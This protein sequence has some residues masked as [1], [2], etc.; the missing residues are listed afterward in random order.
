[1]PAWSKHFP[2]RTK[3]KGS[4]NMINR[5]GLKQNKISIIFILGL[6]YFAHIFCSDQLERE[7]M[8]IIDDNVKEKILV[9]LVNKFGI[10]SAERAKI[11]INQV[12]NFWRESDGSANIF[13]EFCLNHFISNP[14]ELDTLF[15]TFQKNME[16]LFGNLHRISRQFEWK[17]QVESGIISPADYLFAKYNPFA[18]LSKDFFS[19]KLAFTALLNF[20]IHSLAEKNKQGLRWDRKKWAETRLVEEFIKRIPAEVAQQHSEAYMAADDYINHYNIYMHNLIDNQ[21]KIH[22]PAGLKLISHWGLRDELKALYQVADGFIRQKMI[23]EVM[24]R[25]IR[26]ETPKNIVNSEEYYWNP[27]ENKVFKSIGGEPLKIEFESNLRYEHILNIFYAEQLLDPFYPDAPSLIDRQFNLN[28]EMLEREVETELKSILT[29]PV[30]KEISQLIQK[31]LGRPLEPFDIWYN[32]FKT[33]SIFPESDLDK[34]VRKRYPEVEAF[35]KDLPAI[36]SRLGFSPDKVKFLQQHIQ[37]DPSRG[38]GHAL[39]AR[40]NG[41]KAHL[42]TRIPSDGMNYKGY[43]IAIHELGHNVEQIF[44]LNGMDYYSLNG[45]PNTAFTE[46][47]AFVFQSRNLDILGVS[48]PTEETD[49][50]A[51]LGDLWATFEISGVALTDMAIWHWLYDNPQATSED[52]KQAT[53]NISKQIWNEYF[54][55]VIGHKNQELLAIYSHIVDGG[56]YT[57][58]YPLGHI[59]SFQIEQ[60]LKKY[61]LP[62]EMERMCRIGRLT[63]QVWMQRA[64]GEKIS[65]RPLIQAAE[66]SIRSINK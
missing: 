1:M 49:N 58:D 29:A 32:G 51:V 25:I 61:D 62:S 46:A 27:I 18:H 40:M 63:P 33:P 64:V 9:N 57:P 60:F 22:F 55:P 4:L 45:V 31:R 48:K 12:A 36:L 24:K 65:C 44:S 26:Q 23:Q 30:L 66:A 19:T 42:R 21:S 53:V 17:M 43:N 16:S 8:G 11:G 28:R 7:R 5:S 54:Y 20:Q 39:G 15:V 14:T 6:I 37:V 10:S 50:T 35:Q 47:F 41:D 3:E 38:A 52:L 56:L 2:I 34:L 59:I 13:E